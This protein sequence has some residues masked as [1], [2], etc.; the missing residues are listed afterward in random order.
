V[1]V[2]EAM[3]FERASLLE[4]WMSHPVRK[5]GIRYTLEEVIRWADYLNA[6]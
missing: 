2:Q 3:F 4:E 6:L 5:E 1:D